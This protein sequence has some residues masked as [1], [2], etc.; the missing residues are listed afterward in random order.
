MRRENLAREDVMRAEM[1]AR[2]DTMRSFLMKQFRQEFMPR[3]DDVTAR[4][5]PATACSDYDSCII[6]KYLSEI[7]E[8][9]LSNFCNMLSFKHLIYFIYIMLTFI[10]CHVMVFFL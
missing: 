3:Y 7:S 8:V 2:E 10:N 6:S 1:L 4:H 9:V 5:F